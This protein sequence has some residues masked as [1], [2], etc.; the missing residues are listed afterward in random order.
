MTKLL[1]Y[2]SSTPRLTRLARPAPSSFPFLLAPPPRSSTSSRPISRPKKVLLLHLVAYR[3]LVPLVTW[4]FRWLFSP[5]SNDM[6]CNTRSLFQRN[7]Q[8]ISLRSESERTNNALQET[9][10]YIKFALVAGFRFFIVYLPTSWTSNTVVL[11]HECSQAH[12]GK[13]QGVHSS[14]TSDPA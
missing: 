12:C 8:R 7:S 6:L 11:E 14:A 1:C 13:K 9:N 2:S 3:R 10:C 4:N 5:V